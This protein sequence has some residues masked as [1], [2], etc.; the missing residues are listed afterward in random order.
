MEANSDQRKRV[1]VVGNG[2]RDNSNFKSP[3][4]LVVLGRVRIRIPNF[5]TFNPKA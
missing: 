2:P 4:I 1:G 5:M 3:V